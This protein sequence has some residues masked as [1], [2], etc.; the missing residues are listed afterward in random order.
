MQFLRTNRA[1]SVKETGKE[2]KAVQKSALC[3]LCAKT[4]FTSSSRKQEV[5]ICGE[6]G[7]SCSTDDTEELSLQ[8]RFC[9]TAGNGCNLIHLSVWILMPELV[10]YNAPWCILI[11]R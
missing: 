5:P 7:A 6:V 1:A 8:A 11:K 4:E 10:V 3:L 2:R 9:K